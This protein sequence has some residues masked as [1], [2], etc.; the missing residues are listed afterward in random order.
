MGSRRAGSDRRVGPDQVLGTA[1]EQDG[2]TPVVVRCH[3]SH[4]V[5]PCQCAM[6]FKWVNGRRQRRPWGS[7]NY[8]A[9]EVVRCESVDALE[10]QDARCAAE[11]VN[12]PS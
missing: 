5:L 2:T 11:P 8:N 1:E 12:S 7:E 10:V 3:L 6:V 4:S 9:R